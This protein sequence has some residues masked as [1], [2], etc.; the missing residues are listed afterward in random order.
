MGRA[1]YRVS[2]AMRTELRNLVRVAV[3]DEGMAFNGGPAT[4]CKSD[5]WV[6]SER[7]QVR[8][9]STWN[10]P[11]KEYTSQ[12][13]GVVVSF[14]TCCKNECNPPFPSERTQFV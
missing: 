9:G 6:Q 4:P 7:M 10:A 2:L 1:T 14:I 11:T 3:D 13:N 12:D 8:R 5:G